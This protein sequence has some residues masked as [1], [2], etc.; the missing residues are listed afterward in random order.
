[1]AA[2]VAATVDKVIPVLSYYRGTWRWPLFDKHEPYWTINWTWWTSRSDGR[3]NNPAHRRWRIWRQCSWSSLRTQ[4]AVEM[5]AVLCPSLPSRRK[6]AHGH[7]AW[8]HYKNAAFY[9]T[10][11]H[12]L[13]VRPKH[14]FHLSLGSTKES[15]FLYYGG[16]C[17]NAETCVFLGTSLISEDCYSISH[18]DKHAFF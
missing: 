3:T 12:V 14:N 4:T 13:R 5:A 1:M 18:L 7:L 6:G 17:W 11:F 15:G 16:T 2:T 9:I 8:N 10:Y